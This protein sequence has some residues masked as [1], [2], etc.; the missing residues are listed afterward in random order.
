VSSTARTA[1]V[2]KLALLTALLLVALSFS[3]AI[4]RRLGWQKDA[5]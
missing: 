4:E 1:S 2:L 5:T 3:P